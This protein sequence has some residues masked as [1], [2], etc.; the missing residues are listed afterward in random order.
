MNQKEKTWEKIA[1]R[2]PHCVRLPGF[3]TQEDIGLGDAIK[4]FTRAMGIQSCAGCERRAALL[5][6]W[7]VFSGRTK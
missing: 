3:I 1:E 4:S 2:K 5:N 6:S 7:F